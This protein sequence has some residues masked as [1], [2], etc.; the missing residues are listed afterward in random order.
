MEVVK[1]IFDTK[2]VKSGIIFIVEDNNAYGKT[3]QAF[4]KAN[5]P[6]TKEVKLFPVGE[7]CLLELHRDPD[8]IIMDY[9]L[10]TKHNNAGTGLDIIKKIR[11]QKPQTNIILLSANEQV[12]LLLESVKKYNCSYIYKNEKTFE[13]LEEILKEI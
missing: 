5:F 13:H 12:E 1:K 2:S 8:V 11:K 3:L 9:F 10:D 4:L 6:E 7:T